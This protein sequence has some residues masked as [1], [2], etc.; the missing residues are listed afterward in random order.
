MT[1]RKAPSYWYG[2]KQPTGASK[3]MLSALSS[4]YTLGHSVHHRLAETKSVNIPV[5]CIGNLVVGGSGK[6]PAALAI[7]AMLREENL[8]Q[9]PCFLTRGYGGSETGPLCVDPHLHNAAQVGDEPLLLA[10]IAPTFV[11]ADRHAGAKFAE[12]AGHDFIVMD[13]GLQNPSLHKD[14]SIVVIDGWSGFGN[15]KMLPAGPLRTPIHNGMQHIDAVLMIGEDRHNVKRHIPETVPVLK[16]TIQA[17]LPPTPAQSYIGFCGIA[18]PD[19]FRRSLEDAGLNIVGFYDYPDHY[20]YAE[21]DLNTL[22]NEAKAKGARLITTTK[23]AVRLHAT[24]HDEQS[25]D[26]LPITLNWA[27]HA[28]DRLCQ[29][30]K[31]K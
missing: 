8:A 20:P 28:R 21:T 29:I 18:H 22:K 13:D 30:I 4:L 15:E 27:D 11:S 9:N 26:T 12:Q 2:E 10:K 31:A 7:M 1:L 3:I 25:F 23:D 14:F 24:F 19:K 6:T 5:L 16:A 17:Q